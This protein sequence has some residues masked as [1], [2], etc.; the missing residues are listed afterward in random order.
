MENEF[1]TLLATHGDTCAPIE[2]YTDEQGNPY[3]GSITCAE[4]SL[5][6]QAFNDAECTDGYGAPFE[7]PLNQ[8]IPVRENVWV[9][10]TPMYYE[11]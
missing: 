9:W 1:N 11:E 3:H 10:V 4:E 6:A 5:T 7:L 2:D 8:C